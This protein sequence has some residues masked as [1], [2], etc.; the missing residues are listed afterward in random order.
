MIDKYSTENELID[1][2][3]KKGFH[4]NEDGGETPDFIYRLADVLYWV[5]WGLLFTIMV[6]IALD[7]VDII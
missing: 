7:C 1:E 6:I 5:D 2:M 4:F 3:K